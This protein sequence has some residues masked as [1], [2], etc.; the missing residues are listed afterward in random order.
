MLAALALAAYNVHAQE[1]SSA[2]APATHDADALAK[3]LSNPVSTL[4]SVPFQENL[5]FGIGD[6]DGWRSTLNVQPVYP[7]SLR[8]TWNMIN[9]A[10]L[11]ITYQ[12][13]VVG[14]NS[15]FGL[16]DTTVEI[17]FSP[18]AKTSG[19]LIW[20]VGPALLLPTATEDVLGSEKWGAGPTALVLKQE[21]LLTYGLLVNHIWSFAGSGNRNDI[22]STFVQPFYAYAAGHGRTYTIKLESTYD[23]KASQW[24]IPV[25][26]VASQVLKLGSQLASVGVGG[27]YYLEAPANGPEW[28]VRVFVTLMFPER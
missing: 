15:D 7:V 17:F 13:N 9:R 11:P 4:I 25:N 28:G 12:D 24:T 8:S 20:G 3:E 23:W 6:N 26:I 21:G 14:S 16:G 27:R 2:G 10:I 18:K 5:D 1:P 19:G 22:S